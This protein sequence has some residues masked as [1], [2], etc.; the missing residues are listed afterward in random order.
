MARMRGTGMAQR[1]FL[2]RATGRIQATTTKPT[3]AF[4]ITD[5]TTTL[6]ISVFRATC[7]EWLSQ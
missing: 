1:R 3:F 5:S 2:G 7:T 4:T 6:A